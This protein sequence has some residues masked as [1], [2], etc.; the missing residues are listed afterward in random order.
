M[1]LHNFIYKECSNDL[2]NAAFI[3]QF[4]MMFLTIISFK[5][6]SHLKPRGGWSVQNHNFLALVKSGRESK[7]DM[8]EKEIR[9][10]HQN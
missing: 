1:K 4:S 7:S 8:Q 9:L 2:N 5:A 10:L 6:Q 3:H